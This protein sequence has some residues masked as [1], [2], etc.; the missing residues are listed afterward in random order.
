MASSTRRVEAALERWA[1]EVYGKA[2]QKPGAL[3]QQQFATTSGVPLEPLYVPRDTDYEE[4]LG[5][6]GEYP[7]TRGIQPTMYRGRFWTMRQYAGFGT[8]EETNRRFRYLLASGQTGLSTAFDLPTQMGHDS[9]SPRARGEVGRVGV[10]IDTVE[11]MERLFQGIDL[12]KVST[13]MTINATAATL[14]A[15]YQSVA[16]A[17]GT[18]ARELS[19]TVQNDVLKEYIA[20]GT[21]IYPPGP[22]M[23]L[24]TD[25]FAYTAEAMPK[26]NPI[27]ISGYHI[28]EAG[29]TAAQEIAFTLADGIAYVDAA[30]KR[31]LD[32]DSFAGRLSFFLNVHNNFLEEVA[33][34]RAARRLWAR[35]MRERFK[36]KDPRSWTLRFHAQTAGSTLTAQQPDNNVV[37]V[38]LQAFAAVMGGC[39]SLHTNS[40]DEALALPSEQ[41]ARIALRTQQIVA[42]ESGAADLV[43]PL[44]GAYALEALTDELEEKAIAYLTRIDS[45]GG[46]VQAIA[47]GYPQREIEEAAYRYQKEIEDKERVIVGVNEFVSEGEAPFDT[48]T[49]D[50]RLEE[51]Q[52]ERLRA[53]RAARSQEAAQRALSDLKRAA[54]GTQNVLP[55]IVSAVKA[56]STLGEIANALREV[57]GEHGRG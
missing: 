41:S 56:R 14:L 33:K 53:F 44:G 1:R 40:R 51:Q 16:E 15:F 3:R 5:F 6:P 52:V 35:T 17:H 24:I 13:S 23:R 2:A 21:Y 47:S 50:P 31:G 22:S 36:A 34:F 38:A 27:S 32:V 4:K 43:D 28:R 7:F 25:V 48:M 46:M 57:F 30:V 37:R 18:S 45:M 20:R 42:H 19:G 12:G 55:H 26:W 11:D 10:A 39:Q 8:A 49:V 9:D 29:S 54:Q